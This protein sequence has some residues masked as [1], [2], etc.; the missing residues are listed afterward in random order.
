M[1]EEGRQNVAPPKYLAGPTPG[2]KVAWLIP[3]VVITGWWAQSLSVHWEMTVLGT[4]L[5]MTGLIFVVYAGAWKSIM[6]WSEVSDWSLEN[7]IY[8]WVLP[9]RYLQAFFL[10][11]DWE[12]MKGPFFLGLAGWGMIILG[13]IANAV[14]RA[15]ATG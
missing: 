12:R 3:A 1:R 5:V 7:I 8:A 9:F 13:Y 6:I 2:Q 15:P 4:W 11:T 14:L 10:V